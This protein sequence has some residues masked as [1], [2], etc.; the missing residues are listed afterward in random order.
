MTLIISEVLIILL[1]AVPSAAWRSRGVVPRS[2]H[3]L[4]QQ[5]QS[6]SQYSI[7]TI[8]CTSSSVL[9]ASSPMVYDDFIS[10]EGW[11]ALSPET[12]DNIHKQRRL[13][14]PDADSDASSPT[15]TA[16]STVETTTTATIV[17]DIS[18]N[19]PSNPSPNKDDDGR[20]QGTVKW[21]NIRKGF[22]F[23]IRDDNKEEVFV[24]QTSIQSEGFRGLQSGAVV[25]F[26]IE[27]IGERTSAVNVTTPGG[28]RLKEVNKPTVVAITVGPKAE[29]KKESTSSSLETIMVETKPPPVVATPVPVPK[30]TP[31]AF[32]AVVSKKSTNAATKGINIAEIFFD[33][34]VPKT[35]S[36]EYVVIQNS[37]SKDTIDVSGYTVYPETSSGNQGSTFV[38]PQGSSI[39]PNSS[40]RIYTNEIHNETGGYSWG[41]GRALWSNKGGLG[42][43]TDNNGKKLDEYKY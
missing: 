31:A 33:G 36:D 25:E 20:Y 28:T 26:A 10:R 1:F 27:T 8:T 11:Q 13:A 21:F 37:S 24:H 15:S 14:N 29:V 22:G 38:F 9:F 2:H 16:T 40:V 6:R 7:G 34:K 23:V 35:E 18:V 39:K 3:Q 42:V 19:A 30:I 17:A 41:S 4:P 5:L 43:L 32:T 12:R